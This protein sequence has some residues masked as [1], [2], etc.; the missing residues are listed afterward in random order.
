MPRRTVGV[1]TGGGDVPGLNPCIKAVVLGALE[2]EYRVFGIRRGWAGLLYYDLDEPST[3]DYYIRELHRTDVRT[4]DRTGGTVLHT[5]RTNPQKVDPA[6]APDFLKA[7]SWGKALDEKGT[8]DYTDYVLKV[9]EHLGIDVLVAIGGDDTL[10]YAVRLHKEGV[11]VVGIPKTMDNDV[12]GTDYCIGFS[13]AVTRSVEFITNMRTSVGSHERIGVV[14]LFG[15]NSG[16]TSL[17]SA[18]LAYVDRA[19]ISE[20]PFNINKLCDFLMQDKRNNPSN[21]AIMTISEGAVMEGGEVIESGEPDAYGHRKLGGIG[22]IVSEE[23]KR[24][25]GQNTMYQQLA[26]LMRSGAPDS[27]DRMVAMSYG[28]LAVQLIVKGD[29]GKMV[30][31]QGGKYTTVPIDTITTGK[32]RVDVENL[33]DPENYRPRVRDFIGMPMFLY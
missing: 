31:L 12:F 6:S 11:P 29:T 21:Y 24:I 27:L 23:I 18:Y 8:K 26:Y 25:T 1:L 17:I 30:A 9:I 2:N 15:R 20:V 5:S 13:T 32:K 22:L 10:S 28:N 14:E 19:I 4:I 16:E 33:Y 3:H 7:S